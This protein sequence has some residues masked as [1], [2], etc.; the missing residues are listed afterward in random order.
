M[1]CTNLT[2]WK[3]L[4]LSLFFAKSQCAILSLLQMPINSKHNR[5]YASSSQITL[6]FTY[7]NQGPTFNRENT[8]AI[9]GHQ[10]NKTLQ[11][12]YKLL[13]SQE[14]HREKINPSHIP[15]PPKYK[16]E[17]QYIMNS[18]YHQ[19]NWGS[20][21][22]LVDLASVVLYTDLMRSLACVILWR[23]NLFQW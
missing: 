2:S 10:A 1:C 15:S 7:L 3:D 22:I 19:I 21:N 13:K 4:C 6:L 9:C 16:T 14:Q 11:V 17:F 23:R 5:L 8:N 18:Y 20:L 12:Y